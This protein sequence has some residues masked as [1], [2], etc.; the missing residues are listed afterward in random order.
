M[1]F[2]FAC[3]EQK[4]NWPTL[5]VQLPQCRCQLVSVSVCPQCRTVPYPNSLSSRSTLPPTWQQQRVSESIT[6]T[7]AGDTCTTI[8]T[9]LSTVSFLFISKEEVNAFAC[10]RLSVCL[11]VSKITQKR[12]RGFGW[13]VASRQMLGHGRTDYL[14]S[15]IRIT[16]RMP[17]LD[18]FLR[19]RM[20]CNAEFYY[21]GKIPRIA[22]G[23]PSLQ[24]YVVLKWFCSP[25][26][27]GTPLSEVHALHRVPF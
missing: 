6:D 1:L 7:M 17:E 5:Y 8:W 23:C 2:V 11:S 4:C 19:Y 3:Y 24:W 25:R 22:I 27:V 16:V 13:N 9:T 18:C 10:V 15:P 26:A 20:R 14:L 21:V 12:V